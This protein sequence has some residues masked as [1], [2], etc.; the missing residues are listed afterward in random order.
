MRVGSCSWSTCNTSA[1]D[2]KN[3]VPGRGP[4][5][6]LTHATRLARGT[7]KKARAAAGRPRE[8]PARASSRRHRA[9]T[10]ERCASCGA[11]PSTAHP[12]YLQDTS[13]RRDARTPW[14][15]STWRVAAERFLG[16]ASSLRQGRQPQRRAQLSR[17]TVSGGRPHLS[18]LSSRCLT[19]AN[20]ATPSSTGSIAPC[21]YR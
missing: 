20:A 14:R 12:I 10:H 19:A 13:A 9:T 7:R 1:A 8:S 5:S 2:K 17:A 21:R 3:R 18:V 4:V 16:R 6:Q 15:Q 11:E